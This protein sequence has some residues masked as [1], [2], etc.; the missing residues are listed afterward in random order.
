M[1][2]KGVSRGLSRKEWNI[3]TVTAM[4]NLKGT[5]RDI[6]KYRRGDDRKG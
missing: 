5:R 6:I 2:K 4:I 1:E 3:G